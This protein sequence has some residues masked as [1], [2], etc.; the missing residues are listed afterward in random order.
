[1]GREYIVKK[2]NY[3]KN[4]DDHD[5]GVTEVQSLSL[6]QQI[7]RAKRQSTV[8]TAAATYE[9]G[10]RVMHKIFGEGTIISAT[11]AA[12]DFMLEIAF[13]KVGTKKIM[14][15]FAKLTKLS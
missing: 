12:N 7:A 1:M 5:N 6:Q 3:S 13:D 4:K 15:N 14:A 11:P 10:E 8:K 9:A 2:D